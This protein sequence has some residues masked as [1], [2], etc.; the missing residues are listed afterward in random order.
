P[1][2]GER[3]RPPAQGTAAVPRRPYVTRRLG[4]GPDLLAH[5]PVNV[6]V[7]VPDGPWGIGGPVYGHVGE[8][9]RA[10]A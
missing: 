7:P 9:V 10:T 5:V 6:P 2:A 1:P 8:Q 4:R 3:Q